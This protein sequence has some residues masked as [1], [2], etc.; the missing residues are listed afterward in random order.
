MLIS[1]TVVLLLIVLWFVYRKNAPQEKISEF[2]KYQGYSEK[3]YRR[4]LLKTSPSE[5]NWVLP[6]V[7]IIRE[8]R[9]LTCRAVCETNLPENRGKRTLW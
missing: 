3:M 8:K 6:V 1:L 7:S 9:W 5:M 4:H 2:G